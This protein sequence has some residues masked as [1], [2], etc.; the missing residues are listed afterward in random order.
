MLK[1]LKQELEA[2]VRSGGQVLEFHPYSTSVPGVAR[3]K[4]REVLD[5]A[6]W[7]VLGASHHRAARRAVQQALEHGQLASCS[8]RF[9]LGTSIAHLRAEKRL[10]DFGTC[11]SALLFS[12]RNQAVF[13]L[14]TSLATERDVVLCDDA[15]Q[16][17]VQDASYMASAQTRTFKISAL[18]FLEKE[19]EHSRNAKRRFV[20]VESIS[21]ATGQRA[22]IARISELC[23]T[24]EAELIID[25]SYA[26]GLVGLRGVGAR[27]SL[28][29][30]IGAELLCIINDLSLALGLFGAALLGPALLMG[31][32]RERS[33]AMRTEPSL[34]LSFIHALPS[35][36]DF[37]E[38]ASN[39]R[40]QIAASNSK[41]CAGIID[42]F[43]GMSSMPFISLPFSRPSSAHAFCD[44][45]FQKGFMTEV[46]YS[47]RAL[48]ETCYLRILIKSAHTEDQLDSLISAVREIKTRSGNLEAEKK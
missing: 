2:R 35:C 16:S 21:G 13:S 15:L 36:V 14:I 27:E 22:D 10:A 8:S 20:F 6:S 47:S 29:Q 19:L 33:K 9:G 3:I 48:T 24:Y 41:V 17:P 26:C 23:R 1:D 28:P 42:L 43:P 25:E 30:S 45:L 37:V 44:A 34:P 38:L 11:E 31:F 46:I 12:S 32:L 39:A 18:E 7:D 4:G 40:A 5:M